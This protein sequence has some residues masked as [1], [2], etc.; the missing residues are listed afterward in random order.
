MDSERTYHSIYLARGNCVN[1]FVKY[2]ELTSNNE[3]LRNTA[4]IIA[5]SFLVLIYAFIRYVKKT[6]RFKE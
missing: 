6:G 2:P 3:Q 1:P 5:L 4:L